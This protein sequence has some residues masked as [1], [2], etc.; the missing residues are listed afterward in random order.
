MV[1]SRGVSGF[2][3][4]I[5][6]FRAL[7]ELANAVQSRG[8]RALVVRGEPG[9]GKSALIQRLVESGPELHTVRAVGVESE[10]KL[11]FG[12]LHQLC[13]PL[14]DLL[15]RLP[16]P[17]Q[18]ALGTVF[19]FREERP[20]DRLLVGLAVLSWCARQQS[21]NRCCAWSMTGTSWTELPLRRW[22]SSVADS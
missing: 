7:E 3:G 5:S 8:G 12:G 14:L 15:P 6:E 18:D 17:Q 1:S 11:P 22:P 20:P 10:M 4:L 16:G 9:I 13:S 2:V 19:G 21:G